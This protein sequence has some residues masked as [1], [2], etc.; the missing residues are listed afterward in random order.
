MTEIIAQS[1][2]PVLFSLT[3]PL[4]CTRPTMRTPRPTTRSPFPGGQLLAKSHEMFSPRLRLFNYCYPTNPLIAS[5][6]CKFIPQLQDI[7][8]GLQN[9]AQIGRY[10]MKGSRRDWCFRHV[11]KYSKGKLPYLK[12][13]RYN[14]SYKEEIDCSLGEML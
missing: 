4:L 12:L 3:K 9:S 14:L 10:S 8:I 13:F 2:T 5:K 1:P 6:G 7:F 11:N